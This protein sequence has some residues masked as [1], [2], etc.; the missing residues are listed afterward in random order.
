MLYL[1]TRFWRDAL[2]RAVKTFAEATIATFGATKLDVLNTDWVGVLSIGAGAVVLS[3]LA[4]VASA[5][6]GEVD[7]ASAVKL[8]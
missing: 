1:S 7:S 5:N 4:S 8:S 3:L 2:E 6:I